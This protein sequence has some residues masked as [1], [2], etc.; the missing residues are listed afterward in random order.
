M[1]ALLLKDLLYFRQQGK[2]LLVLVVFYIVFF[3]S[4]GG[5]PQVGTAMLTA[6]TVMV[7]MILLITAFSLD[8][9]SKW[10]VYAQAL[11]VTKN[12]I[13]SAKYVLTALL[14]LAS[15]SLSIVIVLAVKRS[16][17]TDD[18]VELYTAVA[19]SMLF[20]SVF[21]P[22]LYRFGVQRARFLFIVVALV[23]TVLATLLRQTGL[24]GP[25]DRD[26]LFWLKVS[27]VIVLVLFFGSFL[28]S[29]RIY[30]KKER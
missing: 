3:F 5:G 1:N 24:P 29:C 11:P 14:A 15:G 6:L 2:G 8:E 10:D 20:G 22:L 18:W 16:V 25:S 28:L 4:L 23:P 26:I 30:R 7:T 21:I 19:L 12:Q 13:V 17:T 27:P 9:Q